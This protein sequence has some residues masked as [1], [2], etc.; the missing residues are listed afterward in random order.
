LDEEWLVVLKEAWGDNYPIGDAMESVQSK[1]SASQ[2]SLSRWSSRKFRQ[3][4][5]VL[6]QMTQQLK[7]EQN[8]E[9]PNNIDTIKRLQ[10]E[11][12]VI[13]ARDDAKWK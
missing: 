1:L 5:K 3:S 4:T 10:G 6:H 12:D 11:I 7:W 8:R 13:L 2:F 9:N